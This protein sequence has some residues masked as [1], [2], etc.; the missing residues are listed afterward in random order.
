MSDEQEPTEDALDRPPTEPGVTD[1]LIWDFEEAWGRARTAGPWP[2][3]EAFLPHNLDP[4]VERYA[5]RE[6]A[7]VDMEHRLRLGDALRVAD[8]LRL[9]PPLQ[10]DA[11]AV[12]ELKRAGEEPRFPRIGDARPELPE[13][14]CKDPDDR[15]RRIGRYVIRATWGRG[16]LGTS[17]WRTTP[18]PTVWWL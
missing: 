15:L 18:W 8:Y 4:A 6:L 11:A 17:V 2:E 12:R 1:R 14:D 13:V 9:L 3:L 7:L 10:G 16:A 5:V